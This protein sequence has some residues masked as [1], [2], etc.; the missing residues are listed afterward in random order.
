MS[1]SS[2]DPF[3]ERPAPE[4]EAVAQS[5]PAPGAQP[6]LGGVS[7]LR[8]EVCGAAVAADQRYCV[9]CGNHRVG[10]NDPAASF[11][12]RSAA[13]GSQRAGRAVV[14]SA[15][16]GR[17]TTALMLVLIPVAI[18]VGILI[19]RSSN[20]QDSKLLRAVAR[21]KAQIVTVQSGSA[22]VVTVSGA[23]SAAGT[24][25]TKS[26]SKTAKNT[27]STATKKAAGS[28]GSS[29]SASQA[30]QSQ[31]IVKKLQSTNGLSYLDPLPSQVGGG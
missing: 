17:L 8:C 18:A 15:R 30:K 3:R 11:M 19:G 28:V 10:V 20:N 14:V 25:Q 4:P 23:T 1:I 29:S 5:A 16:R 21:E 2:T 12:N 27:S 31:K 6:T 24:K 22:K 26:K 13:R 7:S 9:E